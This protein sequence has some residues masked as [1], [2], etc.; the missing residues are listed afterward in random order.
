MI[1]EIIENLPMLL[2]PGYMIF[3]ILY[4]VKL[5]IKER[6]NSLLKFL[7]CIIIT[8]WIMASIVIIM[9]IHVYQMALIWE[10]VESV[11]PLVKSI[12]FA[13]IEFIWSMIGILISWS[14]FKMIYFR[15]ILPGEGSVKERFV[16]LVK[17]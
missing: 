5:I 14:L 7:I 9:I 11:S 8:N 1:G 12:S 15:Q 13:A 10:E 3:L 4:L 17:G 2:I 16:N 6:T